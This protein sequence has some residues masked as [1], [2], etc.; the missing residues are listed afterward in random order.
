V[1]GRDYL[2]AEEYDFTGCKFAYFGACSAGN[3]F[4]EEI[5]Q[6][7]IVKQGI[8]GALGYTEVLT[9]NNPNREYHFRVYELGWTKKPGTRRYYRISEI[10]TEIQREIPP[11]HPDAAFRSIRAQGYDIQIPRVRENNPPRLP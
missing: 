1:E 6:G 4:M 9:T 3:R 11:D 10:A 7:G 5:V 8:L 2:D